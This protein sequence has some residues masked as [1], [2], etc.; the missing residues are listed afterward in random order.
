MSRPTP[1]VAAPIPL[2]LRLTIPRDRTVLRPL[3]APEQLLRR[4]LITRLPRPRIIQEAVEDT[5]LAAEAAAAPTP[6]AVTAEATAADLNQSCNAKTGGVMRYS[7]S[8]APASAGGTLLH[9]TPMR[10][11]DVGLQARQHI[12]AR[13]LIIEE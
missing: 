3:T 1:Q 8:I 7:P 4:L 13:Q 12:L 6:P 11:L 2:P 9:T 10:H 5:P